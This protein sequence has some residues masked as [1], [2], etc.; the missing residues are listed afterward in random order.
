MHRRSPTIKQEEWR[1]ARRIHGGLWNMWVALL[2]IKLSRVTIPSRRLRLA[3][4]RTVFGK[5]YPPGMN[6]AE[7]ELPLEEYPS[8]NAM[9][10]RGIKPEYRPIPAGTPQF[11][12][13]ADGT[14]QDV[15]R[16]ES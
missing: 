15:G 8:I 14:V 3:I 5:K 9:F 2:G 11:L 13:P 16:V 6:E 1:L 4:Y 7:A 12:S 10:V